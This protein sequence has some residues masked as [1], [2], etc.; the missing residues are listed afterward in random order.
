[1]NH[2]NLDEILQ[3]Y[4]DRFDE[5]NARDGNDEGYKWR[6]E[7]WFKSQWDID[8]IDFPKMFISAMKETSNLID[9]ATVQP[10]GGIRML[11][12]QDDE[13]EFVR[14]CFKKLFSEDNGDIDQRQNRVD[15]FIEEINSHIEK[16][17]SGSWKYPQSRGSVIYYLNL[18]RPEENYIFKSTEATNWANCIEYGDDFGSGTS[19]SLKKYY[20][21]CD[22]LLE[23]LKKREDLLELNTQR[24]AADA[25]G[26]DDQLHI[27]VYDV[28]YC[29]NTYLFYNDIHIEK[30]STKERIHKASVRDKIEKIQEDIAEKQHQIQKLGELL[31]LP[32]LTGKTVNHKAF[33]QGTVD[34]ITNGMLLISFGAG[35]K[36]FKYPDAFSAG[37]LQIDN[38]EYTELF[39]SNAN[40]E[41][42]R[43]DLEKQIKN[44]EYEIKRVE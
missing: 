26:F 16:Y 15:E 43:T 30:T 1:M 5:L 28:I 40:I 18:W 14:A 3:Q 29:A 12:K 21:M 38:Q 23:E 34:A 4:I 9:N 10:I 36:K 27:L 19:F 17:V 8:A 31:P 41:K 42:Q 22:E 11:L 33:G 6:A 20:R 39:Q 37:F 2:K 7:S 32:D 35:E 44:L 25:K 13:I 24:V